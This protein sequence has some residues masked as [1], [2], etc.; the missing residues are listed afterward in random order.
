MKYLIYNLF[1]GL[2]LFGLGCSSSENIA[3]PDPIINERISLNINEAVYFDFVKTDTVWTGELTTYTLNESGEKVVNNEYV[4]TR[5]SSWNDFDAF[6]QF[7]NIYEI[8][9][10]N[11]IEGWVPNSAELPRRVYNF[12]VFNGDTTRSFSY[13]DPINDL[14]DFW[15]AQNLLTFVTFIRN[16]LR[17]VERENIEQ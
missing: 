8:E 6:V 16:D 15:Q 1:L 14:Q 10:Q 2:I 9:P 3:Q 13:Q 12:E 4:S 7:L 11:E 5:D 17:W